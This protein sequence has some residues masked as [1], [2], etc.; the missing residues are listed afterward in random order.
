VGWS[1]GSDAIR[2]CH[3]NHSHERKAYIRNLLNEKE[4]QSQQRSLKDWRKNGFSRFG[5]RDVIFHV[6]STKN[7][8]EVVGL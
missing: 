1:S 6:G 5:A 4:S 3:A 7:H 2:M 8:L